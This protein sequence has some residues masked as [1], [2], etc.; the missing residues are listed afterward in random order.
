MLPRLISS[1]FTYLNAGSYYKTALE[2]QNAINTAQ[3]QLY[4]KLR[5]NMAEYG[6][7]RPKSQINFQETTVTSDSLAELYRVY[8]LSYNRGPLQIVASDGR[9]ID[10]VQIIE[11]SYTKGGTFYPVNIVPD[12]QYLLMIGNEVLYPKTVTNPTRPLGRLQG[13]FEY[14]IYPDVYDAARARVLTLPTNVQFSIVDNLNNEIPDLLPGYTDTDFTEDKFNNL[15]F[16]TLNSLGFNI[17]NGTLIQ[18][19]AQKEFKEL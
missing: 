17:N 9:E 7:S 19:S 13:L 3:I 12:N 8:D 11:I 16:L 6:P 5:G 18:G 1:I 10:I 14:E 2:I 4:K 15:L